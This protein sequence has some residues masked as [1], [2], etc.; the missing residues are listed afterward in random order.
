MA[1]FGNCGFIMITRIWDSR[2]IQT[3]PIPFLIIK[4]NKEAALWSGCLCASEDL[5]RIHRLVFR[6]SQSFPKQSTLARQSNRVC[7]RRRRMER[8]GR[9]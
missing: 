8:T 1:W 9:Q 3:N 4:K 2:K 6:T 5:I 7:P